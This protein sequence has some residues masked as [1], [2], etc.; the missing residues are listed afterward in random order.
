MTVLPHGVLEE[1]RQ[2]IIQWQGDEGKASGNVAVDPHPGRVTILVLT[3]TPGGEEGLHSGH[4]PIQRMSQNK[5]LIYTA[6]MQRAGFRYGRGQVR[7]S[8]SCNTSHHRPLNEH[9]R[10]RTLLGGSSFIRHLIK[11]CLIPVS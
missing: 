8:I 10:G 3:Q 6:R 7:A 11:T 5:P 2:D 1:F 4:R 9:T